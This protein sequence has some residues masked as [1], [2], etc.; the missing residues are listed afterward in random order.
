MSRQIWRAHGR[1]RQS[2]LTLVELLVTII[3]AGIAFAALVP[4]FVQA[5]QKTS[6]DNMRNLALNLAQD[7]I[8]RIRGLSFSVITAA[9]LQTN[10]VKVD[11]QFGTPGATPKL[12]PVTNAMVPVNVDSNGG[13]QLLVNYAVED[14]TGTTDFT[15][16]KTITVTVWWEGSPQPVKPAV[17][18]TVVYGQYAGPQLI[19]PLSIAPAPDSNDWIT[20]TSVTSLLLS[21]TVNAAQAAN[22]WGVKFIVTDVSGVGTTKVLTGSKATGTTWTANWDISGLS[23]GHYTVSATAYVL[24]D[25]GSVGLPGNTLTRDVRLEREP[26]GPVQAT[27]LPGVVRNSSGA[28]VSVVN[29]SWDLIAASGVVNYR[30]YRS[31]SLG[32]ESEPPYATVSSLVNCYQDAAV[33]DGAT[34]YYKIIAVDFNGNA[35][36]LTDPQ[37]TEVSATPSAVASSVF[38]AAVTFTGA[39]FSAGSVPL[40]WSSSPEA[41]VIGYYVY[42]DHESQ[43][44][45]F[46]PQSAAPTWTDTDVEWNTTYTYTVEAVTSS[47]VVCPDVANVT[48]GITTD[49]DGWV[50][51]ALPSTPMYTLNVYVRELKLKAHTVVAIR[52][53]ANGQALEYYPGPTVNQTLPVPAGFVSFGQNTLPF[54]TYRIVLDPGTKQTILGTRL[55]GDPDEPVA[56]YFTL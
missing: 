53:D 48:A 39:K 37:V 5:T 17:L 19:A 28:N 35:L 6:A 25:D 50:A 32:A 38:P 13:R 29:L 30:I 49:A 47:G 21:A 36:A 40:Y 54:G 45:Q 26:P 51:V 33:V 12:S 8:E 41:D 3:I 9:N 22:T 27:A 11:A 44:A 15:A 46:V 18:T 42:R 24:N 52:I 16:Y 56:L 55:V 10:D 23:D 14:S 4:V 31:T 43:P 20:S 34:Y 1:G 7:K 2:G